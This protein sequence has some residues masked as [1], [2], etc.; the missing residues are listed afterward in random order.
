MSKL[1]FGT[2]GRFGRLSTRLAFNLVNYAIECGITRFDT[3]INYCRGRSQA[4][5]FDCINNHRDKNI[6]ISTKIS[7]EDASLNYDEMLK[8]TRIPSGQSIDVLFLWGPSPNDLSSS[9]IIR[10][11][12]RIKKDGLVKK[13]GVNTHELSIMRGLFH[14]ALISDLDSVMIDFNIIQQDRVTMINKFG[15]SGVDVWAG[16]SLC[17]GF[18]SYSLYQIALR[19][20]SASYIGRAFLNN[21]TIELRKRAKPVREYLKN[22][23]PD[24]YKK[25][26]L[27]Y[28]LSNTNVH[29]V[30][31]G[32]LSISSIK[33]NIE[34]SN[35]L[36]PS[37]LLNKIAREISS[38]L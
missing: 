20:R 10:N 23:Y 36:I 14:T 19:T 9:Q 5:L 25:I 31:V 22:H 7:P 6:S 3:G 29:Y 37:E 11:L 13:I 38:L 27:S 34:I 26:P 35:N 4:L 12:G 17:Q 2:G 33:S 24:I 16:T 28:V 18:L 30:P 1:V 15:Y 21:P 32:M 8:K